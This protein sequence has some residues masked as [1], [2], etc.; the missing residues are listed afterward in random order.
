MSEWCGFPST[1]LVR[2]KEVRRKRRQLCV[3]WLRSWCWQKGFGFYDRRPRLRIGICLGGM[4]STS[5]K[6]DKGILASRMADQVN[7]GFIVRMMWEGESPA[8]TRKG[9]L[10]TWRLKAAFA[11]VTMRSWQEGAGQNVSSQLQ[12]DQTLASSKVCPR[13][14]YGIQL[15]RREDRPK[16]ADQY[17]AINS[18]KLKCSPSWWAGNQAEATPGPQKGKSIQA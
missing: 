17:S 7:N 14:T 13:E 9:S 11:A 4:G 1:L 18:S 10:G 8:A 6:Q 2:G 12:R 5:F 15:C 3:N 16:K